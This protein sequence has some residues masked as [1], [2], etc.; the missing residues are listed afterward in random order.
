[1]NDKKL[2]D[3]AVIKA[4]MNLMIEAKIIIE[5]IL[6]NKDFKGLNPSGK[7]Y[8]KGFNKIFID[9]REIFNHE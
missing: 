4:S 9:L 6:E 2:G 5:S 3:A 8:W 7:K 1:L